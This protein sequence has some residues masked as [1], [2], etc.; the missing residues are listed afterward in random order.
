M[1]ITIVGIGYVGLSLAILLSTKHSVIAIDTDDK[2]IS[3]INNKNFNYLDKDNLNL[4]A[5]DNKAQA[6][7][8]PNLIVLAL[9]TNFNNETCALDTSIIE[10]VVKDINEFNET[11]TIVIKSTVNIGFSKYIASVY[12]KM[13]FFF[14]P[15]F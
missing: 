2:K 9:P 13:H 7:S 10:S 4:V 12:P 8:N 3:M 6:Y 15:E 11:A 14:S 5:T 1:K